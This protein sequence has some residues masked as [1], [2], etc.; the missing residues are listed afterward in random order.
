[1]LNLFKRIWAIYWYAVFI[2]IFLLWYPIIFITLSFPALYKY[3]NKIRVGWARMT[4]ILTL[5]PWSVH[6][7]EGYKK[8]RRDKNRK[9]GVVYCPNHSSY[10]DIP[11]FG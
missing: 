5:L 8:F 10:L 6:F 1:M 7:S 9:T 3:A 2:G 4:L 11:L